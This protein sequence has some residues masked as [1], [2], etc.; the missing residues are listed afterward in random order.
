M[1]PPCSVADELD[2]MYLLEI[3]TP[4]AQNY[5]EQKKKKMYGHEY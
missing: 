3:F 5:C 1:S 2:Y 4:C